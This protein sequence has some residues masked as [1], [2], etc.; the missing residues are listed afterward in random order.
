MCECE[1]VCV[2]MCV[3]ACVCV[4]VHA[5]V[6]ACVCVCVCVCACVRVCVCLCVCVRACVCV[7]ACVCACL[8]FGNCWPY[9]A[10]CVQYRYQR[11]RA[12][13]ILSSLQHC[14]QGF[15]LV[16]CLHASPCTGPRTP[17][18]CCT[19]PSYFTP[20]S[21]VK[22]NLFSSSESIHAAGMSDSPDTRIH[23]FGLSR[24]SSAYLGNLRQS[25]AYL[26]HLLKK[27]DS[28]GVNTRQAFGAG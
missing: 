24:R 9:N 13:R 28:V 11:R 19:H 20:L 3:C 5:C 2:C 27:E 17:L 6:R 25:S 26:A 22:T 23:L 18:V 8:K 14:S 4:C 10:I 21:R 12:S 16:I 15:D 7:C 1:C